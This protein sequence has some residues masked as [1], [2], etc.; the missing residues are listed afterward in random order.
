MYPF[1]ILHMVTSNQPNKI[2][3]ICSNIAFKTTLVITI[4]NMFIHMYWPYVCKERR[5]CRCNQTK[6]P[7]EPHIP[8]VSNRLMFGVLICQRLI[9]RN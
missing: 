7:P 6:L 3:L 5:S 4:I 9:I 8:N 2:H 1:D